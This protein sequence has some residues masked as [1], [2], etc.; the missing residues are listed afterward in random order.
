M[1]LMVK[2][3]ANR[4]TGFKKTIVLEFTKVVGSIERSEEEKEKETVRKLVVASCELVNVKQDKPGTY[5]ISLQKDDYFS[6]DLPKGNVSPGQEIVIKFTY[7][8]PKKDPNLVI[9]NN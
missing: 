5:E 4:V 7:T 8:P 9:L 6:C 2:E 3:K 1:D